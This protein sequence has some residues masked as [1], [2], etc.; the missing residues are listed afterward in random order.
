M[1]FEEYRAIK[2]INF[3]SLKEMRKSP[4]QYRYV[5]EN[6]T[7]DT[8]GKS[9]GRATHTA[10]LESH[11]FND[12]YAIYTG[13]TRRGKDWD[14]FEADNA[15][16]TILKREEAEHCLAIARE[17]KANPVAAKLLSSGE[18][19]KTL[20][21][22]DKATGLPLKCRIDF[23]SNADGKLTI[24]DLKGCRSVLIDQFRI[25]AGK[26]GFHRQLAFYREIVA[27]NFNGQIADCVLLAVEFNRP[28]DVAA[29]RMGEDELEAGFCDNA[30]FLQKV[31]TCQLD[32][33]YPGCYSE[34]MELNLRRWETGLG[35]TEDVAELGLDFSD[36]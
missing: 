15:H 14:K 11:K 9:L 1:N 10:V 27:N 34:I 36:D 12:E 17:V 21:W 23:L 19:E 33:T 29:F 6:G 26:S 3:S 35:D 31:L 2:A 13:K 22:T 20:T 30:D 18:A 24:V 16:K 28:H 8:V 32:N 4:K 7:T 25:D 5:L